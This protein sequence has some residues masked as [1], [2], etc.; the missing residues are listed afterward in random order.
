MVLDPQP[1]RIY[2]DLGVV[3]RPLR[4]VVD[5][6]LGALERTP[7]HLNNFFQRQNEGIGHPVNRAEGPREGHH[8]LVGAVILQDDPHRVLVELIGDGEVQDHG[9][10]R[11]LHAVQSRE[12]VPVHSDVRAFGPGVVRVRLA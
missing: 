12:V 1:D 2:S 3:T 4:D 10:V 5:C 7:V 9:D 8:Q 6:E 11:D